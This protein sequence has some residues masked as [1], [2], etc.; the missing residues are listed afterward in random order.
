MCAWGGGGE[1][2]GWGGLKTSIPVESKEGKKLRKKRQ[3]IIFMIKDLQN[4]YFSKACYNAKHNSTQIIPTRLFNKR[5]H[6]QSTTSP[7]NVMSNSL[8]KMNYTLTD[9][10]IKISEIHPFNEEM[11]TLAENTQFSHPTRRPYYKHIAKLFF[12]DR[13]RTVMFGWGE[14]TAKL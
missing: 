13:L 4:L 10:N 2:W 11:F 7:E 3:F 6:V 14:R 9:F 1:G 5:H 12:S 8:F